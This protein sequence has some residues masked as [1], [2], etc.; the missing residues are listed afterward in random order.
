MDSIRDRRCHRAL[1][2]VVDAARVCFLNRAWAL[3]AQAVERDAGFRDS[4]CG[5]ADHEPIRLLDRWGFRTSNRI[6]KRYGVTRGLSIVQD[7]VQLPVG[8]A[9]T[10]A[11][12]PAKMAPLGPFGR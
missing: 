7:N 8:F 3:S 10:T 6:S 12:R 5:A 4:F 1:P 2:G 11:R 9:V